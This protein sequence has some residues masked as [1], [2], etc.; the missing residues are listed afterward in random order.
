MPFL[1]LVPT[2][3]RAQAVA[4]LALV[5]ALVGTGLGPMLVGMLSDALA[6]TKHPL[7][8]ALACV[9]ITAATIAAFLLQWLVKR[10][11]QMTAAQ[12]L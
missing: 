8:F 10:A 5:T 1:L 11:R 9:G 2:H 3:I 7:P 12:S 6:F 4:F